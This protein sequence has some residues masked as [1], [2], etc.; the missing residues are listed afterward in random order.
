MRFDNR[1]DFEIQI[2]PEVDTCFTK[3]PTMLLQPFVE[4]VFVHAFNESSI[5]PKLIISFEMIS[6]TLLECKI[7]DNG[8]SLNAAKK[9]KLHQ[10]K[11]IQ[12]TKER[13]SLLQDLKNDSIKIDFSENKGTTVTILL[14][15]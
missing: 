2:S 13:L 6:N 10:S 9:S 1:I 7:I 12:L 15:V 14:L 4:N 5:S 3:I 11:G 8:M